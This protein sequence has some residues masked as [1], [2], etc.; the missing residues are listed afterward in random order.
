MLRLSLAAAALAAFVFAVPAHADPITLMP[1]VTYDRQLVLSRF[2]PQVVH[3]VTAPR[4]GGLYSVAPVLSNGT[5]LGK[6]TL[7][8]MQKRLATTGTIVG[9]DGDTSTADGV[10]SGRA[11]PV[12]DAQRDHE[13]EAL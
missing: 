11:G 1:G 5:L 12:R 8:S 2:G 6:E 13:R 4:P 7:T 10:P 3:V 9:I